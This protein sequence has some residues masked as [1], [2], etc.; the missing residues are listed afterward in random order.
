M[1]TMKNNNPIR[2]LGNDIIEISRLRQ[3]IDRHGLHFLNR[4]FSQRE[5]DYC[6]RFSDPAPHFA[7]RFAAKEAIVKALG[8]GFGAQVSWHDIEVLNDALGKPVVHISESLAKQFGQPQL[9]VSI[10]HSTDYATAVAIWT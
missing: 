1:T 5:Q 7:G 4:L 6:Y 3:S 8:T 9:M 10:S 2:G